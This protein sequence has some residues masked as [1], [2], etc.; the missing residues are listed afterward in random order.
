MLLR[1]PCPQCNTEIELD[2]TRAN[3]SVACPSCSESVTPPPPQIAPGVTLGNFLIEKR[4]GE[5]AMG[6]V[7]LALQLSMDRRVALKVLPQALTREARIIARFR[8]EVRMSA[9]LEHPNIVTAF[10]AGEDFGHHFL[11][12]TYVEGENLGALLKQD[13]V[14]DEK[15]A[16]QIGRQIT[17]ALRY[18]WDEHQMLHRDVK[19]T[20]IMVDAGGRARLMD[21]GISI[22]LNE[23][24]STLTSAGMVVGTPHYMSPEQIRGEELDWRADAYSLGATLYHLV[25]GGTPFKGTGSV[26]VISQHLNSPVIPARERRASLSVGLSLLLERMMAKD[27]GH[28][29]RSWEDLLRDFDLVLAG[30]RPPLAPIHTSTSP[31]PVQA[32]PAATRKKEAATTPK[33]QAPEPAKERLPPVIDFHPRRPSRLNKRRVL[34][35][36][37][38][39]ILVVCLALAIWRAWVQMNKQ[40]EPPPSSHGALEPGR[41]PDLRRAL[42]RGLD[43][44]IGSKRRSC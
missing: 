22:C 29:H 31:S 3:A 17:E 10:E 12:M 35:G 18:A 39:V 16:L 34:T 25:T 1:F 26:E 14:M 37:S 33:P 43:R 42:S 19:P 11:A 13:G 4:L 28:R 36:L 23:A 27:R 7:F 8:R 20:N 44:S 6:D 5:G 2:A 41:S 40:D 9:R 30:K 32:S 24:Q 21:L 15:A 38:L